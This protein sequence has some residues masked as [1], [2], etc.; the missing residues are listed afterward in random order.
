[1]LE[2]KAAKRGKRNDGSPTTNSEWVGGRLTTPMFITEGEPYRLEM[3][4]WLEVPED[5]VVGPRRSTPKRQSR[6][7]RRSFGR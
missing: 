6:S 7:P 1:M 3:I 2:G 4:L 5:F